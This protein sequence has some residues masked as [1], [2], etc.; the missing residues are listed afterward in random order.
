MLE[1]ILEHLMDCKE[2]QP[3]HPKGN[4]SWIFIWRTDPEAETPI[5]WPPEKNWLIWKDPDIGKIEGGRRRGQQMMRWLDGITN[6]MDMSLS[7]PWELVLDRE[8][9]CALV[10]GVAKSQIQ[11]RDWTELMF[12]DRQNSTKVSKGFYFKFY[13]YCN[14]NAFV[15]WNFGME[16]S[17]YCI[18]Q[19]SWGRVWDCPPLCWKD[20]GKIHVGPGL[21]VGGSRNRIQ[22][23]LQIKSNIIWMACVHLLLSLSLLIFKSWD[24]YLLDDLG[25]FF[26]S[27]QVYPLE[28]SL[29]LLLLHHFSVSMLLISR[30][31]PIV[32]PSLV[33]SNQYREDF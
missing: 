31:L 24:P 8:A 16:S 14:Q 9:W 32:C 15:A 26:F 21:E 11:L 12:L 4:Q 13:A 22:Y 17:L 1:N 3:I 33:Q 18:K 2:I 5:L 23:N 28:Y 27:H 30:L 20:S 10:R 19:S 6:S 25:H 7:K 29:S